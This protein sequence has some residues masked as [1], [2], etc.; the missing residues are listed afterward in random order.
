MSINISEAQKK[1]V[2]IIIPARMGSSRL[3]DKVIKDINGMEMVVRVAKIAQQVDGISV[4]VA[5]DSDIVLRLCD[6]NNIS[7]ILVSE[8]CASGTDRV[9]IA[10]NKIET[11]SNIKYKYVLNLQADMPNISLK[12]IRSVIENLIKNPNA[13]IETAVVEVKE[14]SENNLSIR[15]MKKNPGTVKCIL[16]NPL[17]K[18]IKC[19]LSYRA[20]YFSREPIPFG[21]NSYFSHLGIYGYTREAIDKFCKLSVSSLEKIEKLEQLRALENNMVIYLQTVH[22]KD[23]FCP[24]A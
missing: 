3:P 2:I 23:L 18:E 15:R 20:I 5:T 12:A 7:S 13:D 6:K 19:N 17:Q 1:E 9:N 21:T 14:T 16:S 8:E 24:H 22:S 11:Q 4:Y 10:L